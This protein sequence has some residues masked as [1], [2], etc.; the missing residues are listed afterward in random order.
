MKAELITLYPDRTHEGYYSIGFEVNGFR[1]Q[2]DTIHKLPQ[3][4]ERLGI[5][6]SEL[7]KKIKK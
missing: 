6:I 1:T 2:T 7:E 5:K 3:I 4:A